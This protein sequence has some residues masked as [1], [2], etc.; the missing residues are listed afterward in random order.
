MATQQGKGQGTDRKTARKSEEPSPV[1]QGKSAPA[2]EY[3]PVGMAGE[4]AG[5]VKEVEQDLEQKEKG[6]G[7]SGASGK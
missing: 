5:I 1:K 7:R 4:K 6:R 2:H 3:D